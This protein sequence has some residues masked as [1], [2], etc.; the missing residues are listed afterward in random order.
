MYHIIPIS[1]VMSGRPSM[2]SPVSI[3]T[4]GG[5]P[6]SVKLSNSLAVY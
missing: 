6:V 3:F 4:P 2:S 5:L 1:N